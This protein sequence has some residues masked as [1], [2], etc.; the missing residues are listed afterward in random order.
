[1]R[2]SE[3]QYKAQIMIERPSNTPDLDSGTMTQMLWNN[4]NN[5]TQHNTSSNV[6]PWEN[7]N[8]ITQNDRDDEQMIS[9]SNNEDEE[10]QESSAN[11]HQESNANNLGNSEEIDQRSNSKIGGQK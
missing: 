9:T 6:Y 3:W 1:M 11:N 7:I 5:N 8:F 2:R 4:Q 10:D